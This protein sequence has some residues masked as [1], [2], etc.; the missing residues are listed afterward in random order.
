MKNLKRR[1]WIEFNIC[2][3]FALLGCR[4][5]VQQSNYVVI[6]LSKQISMNSVKASELIKEVRY[7][8]LE[9]TDESVIGDVAILKPVKEGFFMLSGNR[10]DQLSFFDADGQF[11]RRIGQRGQ[12]PGEYLSLTGFDVSEQERLLFL[13]SSNRQI[14]IYTFDNKFLRS[15]PIDIRGVVMKTTWG[16]IA[17]KDPLSQPQNLG[18]EAAV[19]VSL[20]ENGNELEVLQYR[21]IE[22]ERGSF[23]NPALLKN[24]DGNYYYYPPFQDTLYSVQADKI[25]PKY[26]LPK[27]SFS[28]D[29]KDVETLEKRRDAF[30][31]GISLGDFILNDHQLI[32]HCTRQNQEKMYIYDLASKKL[33]GVSEI[34]NDMDNSFPFRPF[35]IHLNQWLEIKTAYEIINESAML[36]A[37]LK[38]LDEEDN[39]VIR[40]S[41]LKK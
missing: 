19:L 41:I 9:T 1:C 36:P 29:I 6:D 5:S 26:V 23:F 21:K 4:Q 16:Y 7:I 25:I 31:R 32:L 18:K 24:F 38:N 12:G 27:G 30:S 35:F 40:I 10:F 8:P 28:I 22:I 20:D 13:Y 37:A 15:I 11:I 3:L 39:P 17:Y 34:V 33:S 14:L 2:I